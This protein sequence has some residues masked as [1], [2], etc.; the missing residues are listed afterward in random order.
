MTVNG[1]SPT[2]ALEVQGVSHRYG[3]RLALDAV[4]LAVAPASFTLLLGLNGAGKST[5]FS[6]ITR[7]YATRVGANIDLRSRYRARARGGAR[8]AR[9]RVSVARA[10]SR[11]FG[12]AEPRLPR[13]VAWHRPPPGDRARPRRAR[14]GRS[15]RTACMNAWPSSRAGRCGA[16]RSRAPCLHEPR[17][18][19]LDEPTVGLD[20]KARAGI[21]EAR[22]RPAGAGGHRRALG[23]ASHRRRRR[24]ATM[25]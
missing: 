11:H 3:A 15:R 14:P 4:S 1:Q 23:D 20:V 12:R 16:S 10:R 13:S 19:L 24:R 22:A 21:L 17:L 8:A 5:L 25:S 2:P 6:L 18:L 7:L 9:R